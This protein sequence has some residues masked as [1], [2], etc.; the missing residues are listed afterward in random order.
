MPQTGSIAVPGAVLVMHL[1]SSIGWIG[2]VVVYLVLVVTAMNSKETQ[3]LRSVWLTMGWIGQYAIVPLALTSLLTG[4]VISLGTKWGLFQ[5]YWVIIS[6]AFTIFAAVVL[7]QHMQTVSF[8]ADIAARI[9]TSDIDTLRNGLPGEL[10]HA[11]VGLLVLMVAQVLNVYKPRGLTPYGWR[12]RQ[13][14]RITAE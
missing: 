3:T 14:Q 10:F 2:A 13:V 6:L 7:I 12:K 9:S 1:T 4:I 5:H 8:Y 11:G